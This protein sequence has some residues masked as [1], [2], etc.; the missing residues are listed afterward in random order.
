M[1]TIQMDRFVRKDCSAHGPYKQL[2]D[3]FGSLPSRF[4]NRRITCIF[5]LESDD[6]DL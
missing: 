4:K 1:L 5:S 2:H 6:V 3:L